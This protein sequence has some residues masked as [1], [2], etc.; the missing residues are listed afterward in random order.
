MWC[1]RWRRSGRTRRSTRRCTAPTRRFRSSADT[2][3]ARR[4]STGCPSIDGFRNLFPLYPAAFRALRRA[5]ARR[6]HLE[7]QRLGAQRPHRRPTASTRCT[8]TPR[9]A[10]ST[11]PTTSARLR[12]KQAL[13]PVIGL[14]RRWD[15]TAARTG[16]SVHR[17]Q[18][19][20]YAT[21]IKLRYGIDAPVVLSAGRRRSLP[22]KPARRAAA[23]RL[24]AA[25]LQARGFG[26]RCRNASRHRPRRRRRRP[27]ARRSCGAAPGPTVEFHGRLDDADDHRAHG[28]LP[29][30]LL[31]RR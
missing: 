6:R 18:R 4:R 5:P 28:G 30:V 3:C 12:R 25:A 31:A 2:T 20:K 21:R 7:L 9:R 23:R 29:R 13:R 26:R 1:L 27:G 16:R 11:A 22:T 15:R 14:V 19:A 17:E 24:A 8:A 10:G